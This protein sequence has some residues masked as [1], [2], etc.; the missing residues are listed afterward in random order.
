MKTKD[1]A[2]N[3]FNSMMMKKNTLNKFFKRSEFGVVTGLILIWGIFYILS[4]KFFWLSNIGSI[5]TQA[6]EMCVIAVGMGFL[7]ISGEFDLSVGSVYVVAPTIMIRVTQWLGIPIFI[8][9]LIGIAFAALVGFINGT[10]TLKFKL[11]S[12]ITTLA[13][14]MLI[15]GVLLAITGGFISSFL[16]KNLW[17]DILAK[18]FGYIRISTAWMILIVLLFHFILNY[19][20]Y[21]NWVYATGG[22]AAVALKMGINIKKVKMTNFIICSML[23]G[24]AGCIAAARSYSMS[25]A[26]G[27]DLMFN[28][29][30]A[31]IIGGCL[32]T[33]GRGSIIGT[34]LGVMLVSSVN[35]GLILAGA[36]PYWYR[37][38]VGVIILVV[39]IVNLWIIGDKG[40][41][42][43]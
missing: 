21:G 16:E 15:S 37:A 36:S 42:L 6:S 13:T 3:G 25:P 2:G 39:V 5:L 9:F 1:H 24:F 41:V 18:R 28:A 43:K 34:F 10:I 27:F 11:P 17:F 14:M 19:T 23:A 12:F 38:F 22:N 29:M 32:I 33:G 26:V 31:A 7:L 35:S 30:T 40:R 8:G 4:P 20:S